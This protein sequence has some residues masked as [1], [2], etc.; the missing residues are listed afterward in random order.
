MKEIV[1]HVNADEGQPARTGA[2]IAVARATGG[3]VACVY[4][5]PFSSYVASD[6]FG[7]MYDLSSLRAEL[8]ASEAE[9]REQVSAT[10]DGAGIAFDWQ[11]YDGGVGAALAE[12]ARLADLVVVSQGQPDARNMT[13][14]VAPASL[15]MQTRAPVLAVAG[16]ATL[17]IAGRALVAWNGSA[18]AAFALRSALPLLALAREVVVVQVVAAAKDADRSAVDYLARHGVTATFVA[19]P[20]PGEAPAQVLRSAIAT[21]GADWIVCGA[22]GHSRLSEFILGGV[23]RDLMAGAGV[24]MVMA[25]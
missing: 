20:A 4:V 2:A 25:H 11:D 1:L 19:V 9:A 3:H 7:G 14:N 13:I 15:A 18:E 23:T 8:E 24:P 10:L 5:T 16:D 21:H 6:S 22:Y 12:R 17:N